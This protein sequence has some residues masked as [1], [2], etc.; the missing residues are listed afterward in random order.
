ML[1]PRIYRAAVVPALLALIVAA[2]S[3]ESPPRALPAGLPPDS[4]SGPRA[5]AGLRELAAAFPSRAPGSG[6]DRRLAAR[7]RSAL[8]DTGFDVRVRSFSA[9]TARGW[10]RLQTVVGQRT[11]LSSRQI[12]VVAHRDALSRPALAQLSGTAGLL[13]LARVFQGRTL[14]KTLVLVS[15]S[16]GSGGAAGAAETARHLEGPV[17]AVVVLGDLAGGR[18]RRPIVV[19]WS[20]GE[21]IAPPELPATMDAA[22]RL[23]TVLA[24]GDP[25]V[26]SQFARLAFPVTVGE[27]GELAARGLPAALLSVS[28]ER[29]PAP[30]DPVSPE[31]FAAFGRAA[32]RTIT[33]LDARDTAPRAP[34]AELVAAG[35]LLPGWAVRLLVG[36][37]ILPALLAAVDGFARMRRRRRPVGVWVVWVLAGAIPFL[38]A[39]GFAW[40][41]SVVGLMPTPP[42]APAPVGA[43]PLGAA[44]AAAI[45]VVALVA[46]VGWVALRPLVLRAAGVRGDPSSPGAAA[47]LA[48]VLVAVVG[49]AWLF[50]PFAAALLLGAL[51]GWMLL[52]AP[53]VRVRRSVALGLVALSLAPLA[54]V[55]LYYGLAL[56]AGPL[57]LAW[58]WL[59]IAVGGQVGLL[60]VIWWSALLGCLASVLAIVRAKRFEP[61][62]PVE[63]VIRG[64]V[65]YA[66]PGSL[67]GTESAL[68]R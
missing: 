61:P 53:E 67:G 38:A 47:A 21:G 40:L 68:R 17:D 27:Q 63:A 26:L 31:R 55:V 52:V 28:G 37:L 12:V 3:I 10:Q 8:A 46:V 58:N 13:E 20:N 9:R 11:G 44:A 39:A 1:D 45:T 50:N 49:L 59:L 54:L 23:E 7:V 19:P 65:S 57:A 16:G 35:K 60:G 48:L 51:H 64:P 18:V 29:G 25:G 66:G 5:S 14:H 43:V 30:G 33:A 22:V 4:F 36:A 34:R 15:T 42:P 24:P 62:E 56:G 6:G 41:L 32:L 2:F